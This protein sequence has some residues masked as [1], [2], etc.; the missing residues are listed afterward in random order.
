MSS[1]GKRDPNKGKHFFTYQTNS[2]N[3]AIKRKRFIVVQISHHLCVCYHQYFILLINSMKLQNYTP[4]IEALI[5]HEVHTDSNRKYIKEVGN[6]IGRI[7]RSYSI[8]M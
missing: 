7:K 3:K 6:R 4:S 1:P 8:T 5:I 2:P